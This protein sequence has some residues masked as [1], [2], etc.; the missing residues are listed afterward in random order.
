MSS[1][2]D[3]M[4]SG[5]TRALAEFAAATRFEDLPDAVVA[6]AK[7]CILDCLGVALRSGEEPLAKA[8]AATL[9]RAAPRG[10]ATVWGGA[11]HRDSGGGPG[12][13]LPGPRPGLR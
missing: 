11:P 8:Q 4:G 10:P 1:Q 5:P 12:Q 2:N 3:S 9:E 6:Q 13:R 7:R